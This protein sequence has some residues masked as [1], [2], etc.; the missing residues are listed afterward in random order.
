M[1]EIGTV[2]TK[3]S[4]TTSI[5]Y[6]NDRLLTSHEDGYIRLWD[7]RSP[8]I[9]TNTY[10][11]H[12]KL[13]SSVKFNTRSNIFASVLFILMQ[14]SYDTT[15]KVW[16]CRSAFP[17]QNIGTHHDKVFSVAWKEEK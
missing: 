5:D 13:V 2:L 7:I 11:A 1:R 17:L 4:I 16:D 9:P 12:P 8:Q 14:G 15:V 10:K 3:D 6:S